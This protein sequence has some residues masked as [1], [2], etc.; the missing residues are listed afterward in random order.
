M[1]G[2]RPTS[3]PVK[4]GTGHHHWRGA[5]GG[6]RPSSSRAAMQS[7]WYCLHCTATGRWQAW[8]SQCSTRR[9]HQTPRAAGSRGGWRGEGPSR[10]TSG[11]GLGPSIGAPS[12]STAV[13][14]VFDQVAGPFQHTL[15]H[16]GRCL[17]AAALLTTRGRRSRPGGDLALHLVVLADVWPQPVCQL[18]AAA[19]RPCATDITQSAPVLT[20]GERRSIKCSNIIRHNPSHQSAHHGAG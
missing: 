5:G 3:S 17:C 18:V 6:R 15:V 2:I 16:R 8:L 13:R 11:G 19:N 1:R 4:A 14:E 9:R 7:R 20:P 10:G 12:R